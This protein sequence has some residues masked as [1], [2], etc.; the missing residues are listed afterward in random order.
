MAQGQQFLLPLYLRQQARR[1]GDCHHPRGAGTEDTW[2]SSRVGDNDTGCASVTLPLSDHPFWCPG[3][4]HHHPA[5]SSEILEPPEPQQGCRDNPEPLTLSSLFS[6]SKSPSPLYFLP[7]PC[8]PLEKWSSHVPALLQ[9][10]QRQRRH[11]N[12]RL[13]TMGKCLFSPT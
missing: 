3:S 12:K 13:Q 10:V 7:C 8:S 1:A 9:K 2:K 4:P 11:V 5:H 6:F